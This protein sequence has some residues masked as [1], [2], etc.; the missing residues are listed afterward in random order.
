[1]RERDLEGEKETQKKRIK[2]RRRESDLK[3]EKRLKRRERD[4][5]IERKRL[6]ERLREER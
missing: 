1:M 6:N 5:E 4:S 2:L 3:G